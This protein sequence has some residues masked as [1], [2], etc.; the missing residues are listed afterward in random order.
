MNDHQIQAIDVLEHVKDGTSLPTLQSQ[1]SNVIL[2]LL[3]TPKLARLAADHTFPV[4]FAKTALGQAPSSLQSITG[5]VDA[6]VEDGGQEGLS[7]L[8]FNQTDQA[9]LLQSSQLRPAADRAGSLR[10][11]FDHDAA[12]FLTKHQWQVQLPLAQTIFSTGLTSTLMQRTHEREKA[13][14][15]MELIEEKKLETVTLC[16]PSWTA[17]RIEIL[18]SPLLPLT[19]CQVVKSS[20]G[21]IVRT[22]AALQTPEVEEPASR[23]LEAAVTAYF[24]ARSAA[25]EPVSVWALVIPGRLVTNAATSGLVHRL[26]SAA[27]QLEDIWTGRHDREYSSLVCDLLPVGGRLIKVLSGG[28]GWGKKAGLLSLDPDHEYSTRKLRDDF[29]W[30]FDFDDA[31]ESIR[32]GHSLD[33]A[34]GKSVEDGD[35]LMFFTSSNLEPSAPPAVPNFPEVAITL[36]TWLSK[37]NPSKDSSGVGTPSDSVAARTRPGSFSAF[38]EE[39]LAV[40]IFEDEKLIGCS[41]LEVSGMSIRISG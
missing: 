19:E 37:D 13:G 15:D 1:S 40:K 10:L 9:S 26:Q 7:Y 18:S 24:E 22:V 21:N 29:G 16:I 30:S 23:R 32:E 35:A 20:M 34:L 31:D 4:R 39:G 14:H 6:V 33:Q 3:A 2:L 25:P 12:D 11:Q 38:S 27:A 8:I 28:G 36:G 17:S 41:K 5:I